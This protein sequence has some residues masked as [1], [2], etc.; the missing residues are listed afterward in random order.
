V[1]GSGARAAAWATVALLVACQWLLFR[2]YVEREVAWAYPAYFDQVAPLSRSYEILERIRSE[3]L[4]AGLRE[5]AR[6]TGASGSLLP[7]QAAVFHRLF[8]PSRLS[9]LSINLVHLVVFQV[10]LV[11]TLMWLTGRWSV[12]FMGLGLLLC[13]GSPFLSMGGLADLRMDSAAASLMG[14]FLC[15]VIRSRALAERSWSLAAG[16]AAALLVAMRTL[17]LV[18]LGGILG[19]FGAILAW[20]GRAGPDADAWRRRWT[21][22]WAAALALAV[23]ALP[24]LWYKWQRIHDYYVV[25]HLTGPDKWIQPRLLGLRSAGDL[26]LFYPLSFLRDH[27]GPRF[28]AASAALLLASGLAARATS[29]VGPRVTARSDWT[30][31]F[32]FAGL[33]FLVPLVVLTADIAKS[34]VV[35]GILVAPALWLVLLG[36][37]RLAG[38]EAGESPG[39]AVE[40]GLRILGVVVLCAGAQFQWAAYRGPG[41]FASR[42]ADVEAAKQLHGLL[43]ESCRVM[44]WAAPVVTVDRLAD[45]LVPSI[46]TTEMYE[47][48]GLF[49]KVR[50]GVWGLGEVS[51]AAALDSIARS[52]V[53]VLTTSGDPEGPFPFDAS[54]RKLHPRLVSACERDHVALGRFRIQGMEVVPYA[55]AALRVAGGRDGMIPAEGLVLTGLGPVLRSRPS[56]ELL[57]DV[58]APMEALPEV[59]ATAGNQGRVPVAVHAA[60]ALSGRSYRIRLELPPSALDPASPVE[61]RVQ[62]AGARSRLLVPREVRLTPG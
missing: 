46:V 31:A 53:V 42:R 61:V 55:R 45:F 37:V 59:A 16:A 48:R 50:F 11:G 41:P 47:R 10:A 26:L 32:G 6:M 34:L 20:R 29:R 8:G 51:E 17:T 7:L 4:I 33:A 23:A 19:G 2:S 1:S 54:L 14:L 52:D 35:A 5:G 43:G 56:V 58:E 30:A 18:Y 22:F 60:L 12:A 13:A 9:A 15:L 25:G 28:L 24:L 3:G 38:A 40:R 36:V 39:P 27:T 21:G 57:G 44:G 49:V 62:V